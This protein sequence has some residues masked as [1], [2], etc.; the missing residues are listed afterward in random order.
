MMNEFFP[1]AANISLSQTTPS[2]RYICLFLGNVT[3][4][5]SRSTEAYKIQVQAGSKAVNVTGVTPDGV[6]YGGSFPCC[7]QFLTLALQ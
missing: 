7:I 3:Q 2:Q 1:G 4:G 5:A 6:F